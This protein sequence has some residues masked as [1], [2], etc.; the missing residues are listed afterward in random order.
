MRTLLIGLANCEMKSLFA[1][2][3]EVAIDVGGDKFGSSFISLIE[4][5]NRSLRHPFIAD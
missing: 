1:M 5:G 3:D 2:Q 4:I